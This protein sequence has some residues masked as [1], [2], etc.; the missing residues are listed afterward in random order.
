MSLRQDRALARHDATDRAQALA[1]VLAQKLWTSLTALNKP[2]QLDRDAFEVDAAGNLVFP[3]PVRQ[4]PLGG[5]LDTASLGPGQF[6]LWLAAQSAEAAGRPAAAVRQAYADFM[7]SQPP[8][9]FAATAHYAQGLCWLK[10]GRP[11]L[12]TPEFRKVVN[13][14]PRAVG[15]TGLPLRPLAELKLLALTVTTATPPAPESV[16][17]LDSVCSNAVNYP[18]PVSTPILNRVRELAADSEL[19]RKAR[20]WNDLWQQQQFCRS[21]FGAASPYSLEQPLFWFTLLPDAT[22]SELTRLP[23]SVPVTF[24]STSPASEKN[25]R[26]LFRLDPRP[27]WFFEDSAWLA[28]GVRD[29]ASNHWFVCRPESEL[30]YQLSTLVSG[31]RGIPDYFGVGIELGGKQLTSSAWDLRVWHMAHYMGGKGMGQDAKAYTGQ[32]STDVLAAAAPLD[33]PPDSLRVK[34]Y[35]TSPS[36]LYHRQETRNFWF[37]ALI[38][39]SAV[40]AFIGWLAAWRAFHRQQELAT[41]KSNFVSSVSHELRAPLASVRLMAESLERG[42]VADAPRQHEYFGFIVQE[43]RR[44]SA[45]IENVLDFSRIEQGRKEYE[46]EPT[47]LVGLTQQTVKLMEPYAAEKQIQLRFQLPE[48]G[49]ANGT[50]QPVADGKALQQALVNL[51][52]NAIKHSPKGE[53]VTV[54]L[55]VQNAEGGMQNPQ[56]IASSSPS[57]DSRITDLSAEVSAKAEHAPPPIP[58]ARALLLWVEDHGEGIPASEHKKIFER[59]YRR[60]SELRRETQGVGI[61]LSIVKHIVEAHS[62]R[63]L[64]SSEV[65]RGSRFTIELPVWNAF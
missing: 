65:G 18:S 61:G 57:G 56:P 4:A 10:E 54:G 6:R 9:N 27:A 21:L 62:G 38:A 33:A 24:M 59:F 58:K 22:T 23:A 35:L 26:L 47:D 19:Q 37:G 41:L 2:G 8:A 30:G 25:W 29:S 46:F 40:A 36:A 34:I 16:A 3:R 17:L 20:S 1:E 50:F 32:L 52:D 31:T 48:A 42:K 49:P 55:E 28:F 15:D 14:Y 39:A 44:L 11:D 5:G 45:L 7:G 13:D 12:A 63:V 60:G 53:T 51:L 64:V 43:C